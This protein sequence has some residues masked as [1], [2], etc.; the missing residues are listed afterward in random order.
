MGLHGQR[1]VIVSVQRQPGA[2]SLEVADRH[3]WFGTLLAAHVTPPEFAGRTDDYV[4]VIPG[5][6]IE[7]PGLAYTIEIERL[8]GVVIPGFASRAAP[9]PVVVIEDR[10]DAR[11]KAA[12]ER[13][14]GRRSVA[15]FSAEMVRFG[16]TAGRSPIPCAAGQEGCTAGQLVTPVIDDQYFRIEA[17][18]T[19][20]PLRTAPRL[21]EVVSAA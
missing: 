10:T 9:F 21:A 7:P 8:D 11:E 12:M 4:A 16:S 6:E 17:G 2:N 1:A 20:R 18:Y 15:S 3:T 5:A 14:L 13:L 19:Y